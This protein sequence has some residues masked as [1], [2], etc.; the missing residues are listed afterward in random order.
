[1]AS[2]LGTQAI[3]TKSNF[4]LLPLAIRHADQWITWDAGDKRPGRYETWRTA[5]SRRHIDDVMPQLGD[6]LG[7]ARVMSD[8]FAVLDLDKVATSPR[9]RKSLVAWAQPI[10]ARA[11]KLG[12]VEWSHS[13]RGLHIVMRDVP[14]DWQRKR[15]WRADDGSGY[16]W[17]AGEN[18]CHLTMDSLDHLG[19]TICVP[20]SEMIALLPQPVEAV[21]AVTAPRVLATRFDIAP[22]DARKHGYGEN[23]MERLIGEL[24]QAGEGARNKAL[25]WTSYRL[26]QLD[27][28]GTIADAQRWLDVVQSTAGAIG[29]GNREIVSTMR[30]GYE[31]GRLKPADI[32]WRNDEPRERHAADAPVQSVASDAVVV[33][34]ASGGVTAPARRY[35]S[36][37]HASDLA[38][39]PQ[40]TW[41][42]DKLL[43]LG[44]ITQFFGKPGAGK[45]LAALDV[46]LTIAQHMPV[47]YVA[48][49]APGEL[50]PRIHAWCQ[51]TRSQGPGRFYVYPEAINLRDRDQ[52][53]ALSDECRAI[54]ARMIII[55]PLAEC[56]GAA[57]LDENAAQDMGI[58]VAALRTLVADAGN[59]AL[60]VVHHAGWDDAH[61]RGSSALRGASRVVV[62]VAADADDNRVTL[63]VDK[64]NNGKPFEELYYAMV[65]VADSVVLTPHHRAAPAADRPLSPMQLQLLEVLMLQQYRD[66][67]SQSALVDS[68]GQSRQTVSKSISRLLKRLMIEQNNSL[69]TITER[70]QQYLEGVA[71]AG[72]IGTAALASED[73]RYNWRVNPVSPLSPLSP[74]LSPP[75]P[76]SVA[77]VSP[78]TGDNG[79]LS[80]VTGDK[81]TVCPLSPDDSVP[82]AVASGAIGDSALQ[83][84]TSPELSPMSPVLSP[85]CPLPVPLSPVVG[86]P[87]RPPTGDKGQGTDHMV[88]DI[89]E[90]V[91]PAVEVVD[92]PFAWFDRHRDSYSANVSIVQCW[93]TRQDN[94]QG[95]DRYFAVADWGTPQAAI[96]WETSP[97]GYERESDARSAAL[98]RNNIRPG[99]ITL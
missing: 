20:A 16:D 22:S 73:G 3:L 82:S 81:G 71:A 19:G 94:G 35:T 9:D 49:E 75:C 48:G 78:V 40:T 58:A 83:C 64:A 41:L 31:A 55:D 89:V 7:L 27:A 53:G 72:G 91:E 2:S 15:A 90:A 11:L 50:A 98:E 59:P 13:G 52:I 34:E 45:S 65:G 14:Q 37:I 99:L 69:F 25:N 62:R 56:L 10:V 93:V 38:R 12:Y 30:S 8:G 74:V 54:E 84:E 85:V 79:H 88:G 44:V 77:S 46:A 21:P 32:D 6:Q 4:T 26:G 29:L 68:S 47:V 36:L 17:I 87:I 33:P 1:M 61:E 5:T 39:L 92:D 28:A 86:G 60:L 66:G 95:E 97:Y 51:H 24:S 42:V 70:G 80:P 57:G 23:A 63:R 18:L 96:A 76:L 67:A 43:G